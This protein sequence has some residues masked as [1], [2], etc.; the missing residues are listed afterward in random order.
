MD[1]CA[2][3]SLPRVAQ[4]RVNSPDRDEWLVRRRW[5]DRKVTQLRQQPIGIKSAEDDTAEKLLST[6]NDLSG[7]LFGMIV[8]GAIL[9][10]IVLIGLPVAGAPIEYVLLPFGL[11]TCGLV[12]EL[13]SRPWIV[14]ARNLTNPQHSAAFPV[15]GWRRSG[16][17]IDALASEIEKAGLPERVPVPQF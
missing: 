15:K 4:K 12:V 8:L 13:M 2:D 17:A 6:G 14:E 3:S 7:D 16:E 10:G 9:Y 11:I 5:M 1:R